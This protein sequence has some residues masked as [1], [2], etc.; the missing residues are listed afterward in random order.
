M[1]VKFSWR[2]KVGKSVSKGAVKKEG[3]QRNTTKQVY[4]P[5]GGVKK[6]EGGIWKEKRC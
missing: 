6:K 1:G 3:L 5:K 2:L 4:L